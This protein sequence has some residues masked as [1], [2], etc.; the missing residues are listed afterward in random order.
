MIP[1]RFAA[2]LSAPVGD[3]D[4]I[5]NTALI[6]DAT[7]GVGY[8]A[9]ALLTVGE[10]APGPCAEV[11]G[12]D[13]AFTPAEPRVGE[14]VTFTGSVAVGDSPITYAW[15]FGDGGAG[16]G[17]VVTHAFPTTSAERTYTVVMTAANGCPS[18]DVALQDV[19]VWP[20]RLYLP[21]ILQHSNG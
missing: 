19:S 3:G 1:V 18:Q 9:P 12:A 2:T 14:T 5:T 13:F 11:Q 4:L 20:H 21:H 8:E 7:W 17:R 15:A 6:T 10:P 16:S